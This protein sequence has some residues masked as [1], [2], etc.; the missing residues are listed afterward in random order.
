MGGFTNPHSE[1]SYIYFTHRNLC[2]GKYSECISRMHRHASRAHQD[3]H[4]WTPQ[5]RAVARLRSFWSWYNT[6]GGTV[7]TIKCLLELPG[8]GSK[9]SPLKGE[10]TFNSVPVR[11]RLLHV[12]STV[13]IKQMK[14][15]FTIPI[16]HTI[17]AKYVKYS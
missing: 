15:S 7:P 8:P 9:T 11:S 4:E 6:I 5:P 2:T 3:S 12:S 16:S 1:A 14:V 13:P 17:S 10:A